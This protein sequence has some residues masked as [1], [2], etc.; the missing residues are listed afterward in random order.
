MNQA[1]KLIICCLWYRHE[2]IDRLWGWSQYTIS[3]VKAPWTPSQPRTC[4]TSES[5]GNPC[6][7]KM[8]GTPIKF[9]FF[10]T[11]SIMFHVLFAH[12]LNTLDHLFLLIYY[13]PLFVPDHLISWDTSHTTRRRMTEPCTNLFCHSASKFP[14][15]SAASLI[16][17]V[18]PEVQ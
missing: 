11:I 12:I 14:P 16:N 17:L 6:H 7:T 18:N 8:I 10:D 2:S 4:I 1:E 15:C 9:K 5:L 3:L 13:N